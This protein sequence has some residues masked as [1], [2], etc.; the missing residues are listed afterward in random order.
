[1]SLCSAHGMSVEAIA[2][3]VGHAG[4]AVTEAVYRR[5]LRP[6]LTEG[7]EVMGRIFPVVG[8]ESG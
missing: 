1:M 4:T 2:H 3:L 5:E 6:V 8:S 7:A